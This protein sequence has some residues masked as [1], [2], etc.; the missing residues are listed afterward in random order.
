MT[1]DWNAG[2]ATKKDGRRK[3]MWLG[4]WVTGGNMYIEWKWEEREGDGM[5][6]VCY[7]YAC[8]E[9]KFEEVLFWV[10]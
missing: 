3:N 9:K 1:G 10:A 2:L 8:L 6:R 5:G 7:K 4:I